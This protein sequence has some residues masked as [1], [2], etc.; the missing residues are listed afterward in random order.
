M[1]GYRFENFTTKPKSKFDELF[2]IFKELITHTSGDVE[3]ALDWFKE[4]SESGIFTSFYFIFF[5][6]AQFAS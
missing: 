1:I 2:K 4:F 3:E 6:T 5:F